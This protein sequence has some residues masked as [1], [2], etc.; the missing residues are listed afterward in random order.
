MYP[1]RLNSVTVWGLACA[2]GPL[3]LILLAI[4]YLIAPEFY[5]SWVLEGRNRE[6]Q[7]VEIFTFALAF[8]ASVLLLVWIW[9]MRA[10]ARNGSGMGIAGVGI[11]AAA[12]LFFAG[13]EISWGQTYF[14]W[15][16]PEFYEGFGKETNLHNT[17][18][19]IHDLAGLFFFVFFF[20]LPLAWSQRARLPAWSGWPRIACMVPEGPVIV[21]LAV[22]LLWPPLT[23]DLYTFLYSDYAAHPTYRDFLEQANEQKELIVAM[24]LLVYATFRFRHVPPPPNDRL[25]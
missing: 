25:P 24:A 3:T 17:G 18:L 10:S 12:S 13:E 20:L 15:E 14:G 16:T 23:K 22:G 9:R 1:S 2:A 21:T 5:L 8:T 7:L 19:R 6:Y 4:T 11:I